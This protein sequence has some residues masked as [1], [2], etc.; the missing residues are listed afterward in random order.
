M[1][2][3][4]AAF[5]GWSNAFVCGLLSRSFPRS[6]GYVWYVCADLI[7][8][9]TNLFKW[10]S[11]SLALLKRREAEAESIAAVGALYA[12]PSA[13]TQATPHEGVCVCVCV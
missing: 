2:C 6:L 11:R 12:E 10:A 8:V 4:D 5:F 13:R 3:V 1:V 7:A 9:G